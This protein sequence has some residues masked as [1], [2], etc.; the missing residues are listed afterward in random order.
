MKKILSIAPAAC[1]THCTMTQHQS[2]DKPLTDMN[3]AMSVLMEA[4]F[5]KDTIVATINIL[6]T[7]YVDSVSD[8]LTTIPS[9]L[10]HMKQDVV[11]ESCRV[12]V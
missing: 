4:F 6:F 5:G 12:C 1:D 8:V 3:E 11:K 2:A 10:L 7:D 9:M